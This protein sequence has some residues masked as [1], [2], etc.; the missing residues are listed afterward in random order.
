MKINIIP[1]KQLFA[2]FFLINA[3]GYDYEGNSQG[4]HPVRRLFRE[5]VM[6]YNSR[7]I[8][9]IVGLIRQMP[10]PKDQ[11]NRLANLMFVSDKKYSLV[12]NKRKNALILRKWNEVYPLIKKFI[13]SD[14]F[15][16]LF[17]DYVKTVSGL[18]MLK[19]SEILNQ[20][21]KVLKFFNLSVNLF[22]KVDININLFDGYSRGTN[23]FNAKKP[24][25]SCSP[26]LKNKL[27]L[28]TIRH[29]FMHLILKKIF[30]E[31]FLGNKK[32]LPVNK[33]YYRDSFRVK[34][35]ENF[36]LA[37]NLF[38]VRE[39]VKRQ[40]NLKF[41]H[42]KGFKKIYLFYDVIKEDIYIR[43]TSLS[44][45]VLKNMYKLI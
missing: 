7:G 12:E 16:L 42:D 33:N 4:M 29:E 45:A 28:G 5:K 2:I 36:I 14:I 44:P 11:L 34:F 17:K 20:I 41:F 10:L 1:N 21:R 26:N 8:E 38:F 39:E 23:Y 40:N 25:I 9:K 31:K 32:R 35:D 15:D 18:K 6:G 37:A 27:S 19:S 22:E 30:R 24:I 43:K 3:A 13:R